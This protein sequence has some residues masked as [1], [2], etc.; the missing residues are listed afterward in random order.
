[1]KQFV[2]LSSL[3]IAL[4][5]AGTGSRKK[6]YRK[7]MLTLLLGSLPAAYVASQERGENFVFLLPISI[8][9]GFKHW[10]SL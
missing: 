10:T 3:Q 8:K 1:V 4:I 7:N 2:K 5:Y 6:K 9:N